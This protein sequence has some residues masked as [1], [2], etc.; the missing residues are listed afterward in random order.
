[1]GDETGLGAGAGA[2]ECAGEGEGLRTRDAPARLTGTA[3]GARGGEDWGGAADAVPKLLGGCTTA[4]FRPGLAAGARCTGTGADAGLGAGAGAGAGASDGF[5][6]RD[7]PSKLTGMAPEARGDGDGDGEALVTGLADCAGER[8]GDDTAAAGEI[9]TAGFIG[10]LFAG[11]VSS[12]RTEAADGGEAL[13]VFEPPDGFLSTTL[14]AAGPTLA[15]GATAASA[16][17]LNRNDLE[18]AP[19]RW[20]ARN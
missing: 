9:A 10:V 6:T 1:M 19:P 2:G 5:R 8:P 20:G 14:R 15:A 11:A 16:I 13:G 7:A 4:G 3:P 17:C 12:A 18:D